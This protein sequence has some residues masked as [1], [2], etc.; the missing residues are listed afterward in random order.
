VPLGGPTAPTLPPGNYTRVELLYVG[1]VPVTF[2]TLPAGVTLT[3]DRA[4]AWAKWTSNREV[5]LQAHG[6]FDGTGD[7][8]DFLHQ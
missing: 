4:T 7:D 3:T 5:W 6:C 2:G 1:E 8:F